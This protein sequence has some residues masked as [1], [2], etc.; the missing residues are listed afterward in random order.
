MC[1]LKLLQKVVGGV[2]IPTL[3]G[4]TIL[5]S[6]LIFDGGK[7]DKLTLRSVFWKESGP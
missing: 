5:K 6:L 3:E 2:Y 4:Q 7:G 1:G